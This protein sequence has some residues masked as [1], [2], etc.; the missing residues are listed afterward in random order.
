MAKHPKKPKPKQPTFSDAAGSKG[1][2]RGPQGRPIRTRKVKT[3]KVDTQV[4]RNTP[5]K[6]GGP[7]PKRG[8]DVKRPSRDQGAVAKAAARIKASKIGTSIFKSV[9]DI[10]TQ[11]K[12]DPVGFALRNPRKPIRQA[13]LPTR[14]APG[15]NRQLAATT[16]GKR[17][18]K[19]R[20]SAKVARRKRT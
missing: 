12:E 19:P 20:R 2:P 6:G 5:V 10:F 18:R 11:I 1:V 14:S 16:F 9:D 3:R 7:Q 4:V 13:V 17:P 8:P 15:V